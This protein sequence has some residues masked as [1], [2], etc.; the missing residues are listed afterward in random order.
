M[1]VTG[2]KRRSGFFIGVTCPAC[3]ADLEIQENFFVLTCHHC[4]SAM[5]IVMPETPPAYIIKS[6]FGP[7]EARFHLDHH[8]KQ[9][10]LPLTPSDLFL[11]GI[12]YPYW[13]VT[14]V[15]LKLRNRIEERTVSSETE[16]EPDTS[17]QIRKSE[18]SL[19]PFSVT[20]GAGTKDNT[21]PYSLGMRTDYLKM[22]P[23]SNDNVEQNFSCLPVLREWDDVQGNLKKNIAGLGS[24]V[25]ADF[26]KN[27]TEYFHARG[28]LVFFPY[29]TA[30][31]DFSGKRHR[32]II[33]AVT[34]R[35]SSSS[36]E[37]SGPRPGA[38]LKGIFDFGR[39]TVEPHRCSNCGIDLPSE[40]SFVYIC[41][42]CQK[43]TFLEN[44]P[45]L[46]STICGATQTSRKGAQNF[47]FWAFRLSESQKRELQVL[48]GGIYQSDFLVVPAFRISNFE[49]L[50]RLSKRISSALPKISLA[51]IDSTDSR[52]GSVSVGPGEASSLA[53]I[54]IY[55][56]RLSR[57]ASAAPSPFSPQE[58]FLFYAPFHLENYFFVDSVLNAVTF[59][60]SLA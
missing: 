35:V 51:E 36:N 38:P 37:E 53:E 47:P 43:L 60:K 22:F 39:L 11:T 15:L 12:Y 1:P 42:N 25:Q 40:Q 56:E 20:F 45:L 27:K 46:K 5:R 31:D 6:K 9:N 18:I 4:G 21:I 52:F 50:Y 2:D 55:R 14:A 3:G 34:G 54:I 44:N 33:D 8:C 16:Y 10:S 29:Y 23:F 24:L 30:E 13:K 28:A 26:G 49:A 48:F 19:N 58:I 59:E 32:F 7:V 17:I 41:R 57:S